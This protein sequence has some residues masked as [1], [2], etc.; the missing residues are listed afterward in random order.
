[1]LT[2]LQSLVTDVRFVIFYFTTLL[3]FRS[4]IGALL[5][6]SKLSLDVITLQK[7]IAIKK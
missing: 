4:V 1:M 7:S 5:A 6:E 3:F 2:E